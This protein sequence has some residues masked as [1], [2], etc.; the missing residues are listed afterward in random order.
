MKKLL[1][2]L[3]LFV[4]A[5]DKD[6]SIF[7]PSQQDN[8]EYIA[9]FVCNS[10]AT[11]TIW[12]GVN[13]RYFSEYEPTHC[14]HDTL[15]AGHNELVVLRVMSDSCEAN[16]LVYVERNDTIVHYLHERIPP[17]S[18]GEISCVIYN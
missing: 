4:T 2:V 5:C 11:C 12:Y 7:I 16:I 17:Y 18:T 10:D 1:I 3:V 15:V 14:W 6:D 13:P 9:N 8:V